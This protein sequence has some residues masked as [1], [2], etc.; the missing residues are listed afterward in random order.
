MCPFFYTTQRKEYPFY[1]NVIKMLYRIWLIYIFK[2]CGFGL[3]TEFFTIKV[4]E[5]D[6]TGETS[7]LVEKS[8]KFMSIRTRKRERQKGRRERITFFQINVYLYMCIF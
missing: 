2:F 6:K 1:T 5:E 7:S 4:D 3:C 8:Y